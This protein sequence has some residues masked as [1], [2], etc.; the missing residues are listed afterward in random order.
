[1][2]KIFSVYLLSNRRVQTY[3]LLIEEEVA[4]MIEKIKQS[5]STV[6]GEVDLSV[7]LK[8]FMLDLVLRVIHGGS[9]REDGLNKMLRDV[10]AEHIALL[11]EFCVGDYFPPLRWLDKVFGWDSKLRRTFLKW[12]VFLNRVIENHLNTCKDRDKIYQKDFVDVLLALQMD[13]A[14]EFFLTKDSIKA[15][16]IDTL[17]AG[18]DTTHITLEWALVELVRNP[19]AMKKAQAD[20]RGIAGAKPTVEEVDINQM[21]YLRA[22]IKETLRMH[23]PA[24][25]LLP[26]LSSEDTEIDG[27]EVSRQ[28][29]VVINVWAIM[30][31][32]A[33]W[34][35]PEEF[36]PERFLCSSLDFRGKDLQF[37]PFGAGRRI[38]PGMQLAVSVVEVTLANLLHRFD[39]E[40]PDGFRGDLDMTEI[41]GITAHRKLPLHLVPIPRTL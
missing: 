14:T 21:N 11:S 1:M 3:K 17:V 35:A 22:V 32:P 10:M 20:V 4:L 31:D 9:F 12:E 25:L 23:P 24:P 33:Y 16:I 36:R 15:V 19:E 28:T 34:E 18:A 2:R 8:E 39:W 13:P 37:F 38:C 6:S 5:S 40:L 7:I 27:Y 29:T 30:R 26:H 41:F